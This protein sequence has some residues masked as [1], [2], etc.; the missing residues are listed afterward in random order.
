MGWNYRVVRAHYEPVPGLAQATYSIVEVYYDEKDKPTGWHGGSVLEW[1][2]LEDLRNTLGHMMV[3]LDKPLLELP[4]GTN[5]LTE[6]S[7]DRSS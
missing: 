7:D 6:A 3:A 4:L 2:T 1:D 5:E